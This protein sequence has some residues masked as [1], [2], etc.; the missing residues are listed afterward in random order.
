[1]TT[2]FRRHISVLVRVG[3]MDVGLLF[4]VVSSVCAQSVWLIQQVFQLSLRGSS[5]NCTFY[6]DIKL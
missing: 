2:N 3:K 4:S 5:R 6:P 1:M